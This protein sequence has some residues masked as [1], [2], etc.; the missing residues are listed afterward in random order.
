[1]YQ[2]YEVEYCVLRNL[3]QL[4]VPIFVPLLEVQVQELDPVEIK[5]MS[6]ELCNSIG[7]GE[8]LLA[9]F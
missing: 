2:W 4:K 1:M 8:D 5:C 9:C 6:N 3:T 7:S